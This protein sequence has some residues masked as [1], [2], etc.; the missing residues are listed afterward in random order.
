MAV[1]RLVSKI[2]NYN[3]DLNKAELQ[4]ILAAIEYRRSF[5]V[6]SKDPHAA[7]LVNLEAQLKGAL[8]DG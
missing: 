4:A 7:E 3:A 6:Q 8:R 1:I 2:L 5:V